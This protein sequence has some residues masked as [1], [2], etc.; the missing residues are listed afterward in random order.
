M[1]GA[2]VM[3]VLLR[4]VIGTRTR[5][6]D[7]I[8]Q[9]GRDVRDVAVPAADELRRHGWLTDGSP[10]GAILVRANLQG[11]NLRGAN[12]Q[13]TELWGDDLRTALHVETAKL[14]DAMTNSNTRRARASRCRARW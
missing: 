11:A 2:V 6:A 4:M 9:M 13:E 10:Q 1:A 3:Y 8:A 12:L 14:D 5:K 7:L